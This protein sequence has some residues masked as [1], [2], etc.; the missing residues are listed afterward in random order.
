M[1]PFTKLLTAATMLTLLVQ[2]CAMMPP[3]DGPRHHNARP[4][5]HHH[6]HYAEQPTDQAPTYNFTSSEATTVATPFADEK[7]G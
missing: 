3:P 5:P 4:R 7:Q 6:R 2:S 1:K